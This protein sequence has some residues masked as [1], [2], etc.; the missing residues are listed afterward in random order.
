[1]RPKVFGTE[2]AKTKMKEEQVTANKTF[3]RARV[4]FFTYDR[5]M[6]S[7]LA[8]ADLGISGIGGKESMVFEYAPGVKVDEAQVAKAMEMVIEEFNARE[9]RL[10]IKS[11][12]VLGIDEVASTVL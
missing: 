2:E 11:F 4:V 8:N 7:T 9:L 6:S 12:K 5:L 1:M 3:C 10:K